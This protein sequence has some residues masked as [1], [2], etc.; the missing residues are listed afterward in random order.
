[1]D[2]SSKFTTIP[3]KPYPTA[4]TLSRW[5]NFAHSCEKFKN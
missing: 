4:Q 5:K 1:M 2:S 3:R